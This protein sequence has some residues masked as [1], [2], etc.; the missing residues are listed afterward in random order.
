[1]SPCCLRSQALGIVAGSHEEGGPAIHPDPIDIEER[2]HMALEE[3]LPLASS[4]AILVSRSHTRWARRESRPLLPGTAAGEPV[5]RGPLSPAIK[6][7]EQRGLIPELRLAR[8]GKGRL[9][10][11]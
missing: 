6:S 2:V 5:A 8:G 7:A 3:G 4:C 1:M 10:T 11:W 9:R